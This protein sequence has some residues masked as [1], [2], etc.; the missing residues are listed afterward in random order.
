[1]MFHKIQKINTKVT[2]NLAVCCY[3]QD[4]EKGT[5]LLEKLFLSIFVNAKVNV[6]LISEIRILRNN[7]QLLKICEDQFLLQVDGTIKSVGL[8][9]VAL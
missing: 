9:A 3:P 8:A 4:R 5:I 1:M 7:Q 2:E 6:N